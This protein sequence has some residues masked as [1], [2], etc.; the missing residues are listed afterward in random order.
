[1]ST[2]QIAEEGKAETR[3]S[4]TSRECISRYYCACLQLRYR[5]TYDTSDN[6]W[7]HGQQCGVLR[8]ESARV[9]VPAVS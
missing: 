7:E 8:G 5:D 3:L 2:C 6:K 1:M 9:L 4:Y